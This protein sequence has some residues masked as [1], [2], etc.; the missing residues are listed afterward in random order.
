MRPVD[1]AR[2]LFRFIDMDDPPVRLERI[3]EALDVKLYYEDFHFLD[4]IALKSPRRGV[5]VVNRNL[6]LVRQRFTIAHEL[7]HIVMPHKSKYYICFPGRNKAM[8][9]A[10]NRFAAELLMPEPMTRR[11]WE[12][13]SSN[14]EFQVEI[15]ANI[16]QVSKAALFARLREL[17]LVYR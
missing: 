4:G 17:G 10:A 15:V 12:K 2:E 14:P 11:L 13:Y 16:L 8:E 3:L 7:G 5:I 9:R 6:P 1:Y